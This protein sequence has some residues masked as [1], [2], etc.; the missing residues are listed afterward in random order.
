[1]GEKGLQIIEK[2]PTGYHIDPPGEGYKPGVAHPDGLPGLPIIWDDA[3]GTWMPPGFV[4]E[5]GDPNHLFNQTTGQNA[6][7]NDKTG[8]YIDTQTGKALPY[9]Q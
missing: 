8:S 2:L 1:M 3:H 4:P 5:P 7:W 6:V 9:A